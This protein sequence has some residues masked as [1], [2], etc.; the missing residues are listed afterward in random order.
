MY[1]VGLGLIVDKVQCLIISEQDENS[2]DEIIL[3]IFQSEKY[4]I[5]LNFK[6]NPLL[7]YFIKLFNKENH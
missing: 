3:I 2:L 7:S 5:E 6:C 4:C 1:P